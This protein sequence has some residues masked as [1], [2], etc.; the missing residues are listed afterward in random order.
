MNAGGCR[1]VR[2]H[3]QVSA[4]D[5]ELKPSRLAAAQIFRW[6]FALRICATL[7]ADSASNRSPKQEFTNGFHAASLRK[8]RFYSH[9]QAIQNGIHIPFRTNVPVQARAVSSAS[10][11]TG[12]SEQAVPFEWTEQPRTPY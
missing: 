12:V 4:H 6:R 2:Q 8:G 9:Y 11:A 10:P 3:R 5:L 1:R 7:R